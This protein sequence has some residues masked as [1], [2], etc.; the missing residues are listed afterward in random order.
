VI[1]HLQHSKLTIIVM[2]K[3]PSWMIYKRYVYANNDCVSSIKEF[4]KM[5]SLN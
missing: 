5:Y 4:F 1:L 3:I 2:V